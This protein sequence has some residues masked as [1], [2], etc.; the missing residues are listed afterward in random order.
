M[1]ATPVNATPVAETAPE[2]EHFEED[3][4]SGKE[5]EE[6]RLLYK[7]LD[8][9]VTKDKL[10]L[11]PVLSREDL[12]KLIRVD[13][14]RFGRILQQNT[15]KNMTA[16][17]SGKRME[18]AAELLKIHPDYNIVTVAQLCGTS[19]SSFNRMFKSKYEMTPAEFRDKMQS[20]DN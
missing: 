5:E 4:V 15:N 13:K 6:N 8:A 14:N 9:I 10:F 18:Y 17:L 7:K 20:A 19:V 16:Y 12:M 1:Q 11:N 3:I 2:P